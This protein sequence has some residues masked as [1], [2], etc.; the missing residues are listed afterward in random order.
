M[1]ITPKKLMITEMHES[2]LK[3]FVAFIMKED[4][5]GPFSLLN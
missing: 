3:K 4:I 5:E 1:Y 2:S